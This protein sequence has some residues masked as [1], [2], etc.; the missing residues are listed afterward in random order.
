[1]N[2]AMDAAQS[3]FREQGGLLHT[4][5]AIRLGIAPRT[6]YALRDSGALTEAARGLYRLADLPPLSQPDLTVVSLKIP[7]GVICL[8]SALDFHDLTT[9]IPHAV[10]VAL[11]MSAEKSRLA[12]PPVKL[13]WFSGKAYTAGI[14]TPIVDGVRIRVYDPEKTVVDCF[15]FRNRVGLDV[16]IEALKRCSQRRGFRPDRLLTYARI[17]RMG[18]IMQPYLE[19]LQ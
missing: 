13:Y 17:T 12:Y 11:P 7:K 14:E 5:E 1:M 8:I 2:K 9:Q 16:A 18:K 19:M 15:K 6:L 4:T 10:H 3:L